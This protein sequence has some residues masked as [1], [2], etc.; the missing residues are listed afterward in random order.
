[1]GKQLILSDHAVSRLLLRKMGISHDEIVNQ[2]VPQCVTAAVQASGG[3]CTITHEGYT[4]VVESYVLV[5]VLSEGMKSYKPSRVDDIV[6]R[7]R[8]RN[9][10]ERISKKHTEKS[11]K[12]RQSRRGYDAV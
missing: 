7:T 9:K 11:R 12:Y 4:Y 3:A 1:M 5:T 6:H 2:C 8:S 10:G